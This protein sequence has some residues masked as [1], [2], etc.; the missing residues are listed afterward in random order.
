[1]KDAKVEN[2]GEYP[3][4]PEQNLKINRWAQGGKS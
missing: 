2:Q 4:A 3:E 1:M